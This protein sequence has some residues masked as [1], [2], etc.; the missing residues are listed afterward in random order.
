MFSPEVRADASVK[1][2]G[3]KERLSSVENELAKKQ[4][5][6]EQLRLV[7]PR[8]GT[9]SP[10][11]RVRDRSTLDDAELTG[12]SGTPLDPENLGAML[13]SEGQ[14]N[15]FC[16]IGDANAWDAVLVIDQDDV[17]LVR[18]GQPVRLMFEESAYH[19]YVSRLERPADDAMPY[20]PPRLASTNGGSLPAKAEPDGSVRPLSTSYQAVAPLDNRNGLLRNGLVGR[21]RIETAPRTLSQRVFRYLSRTFNFDL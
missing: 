21:A 19:V 1:I 17:E 5:D 6:L 2:A 15:L 13:S 20:A 3:A 10:P 11:P 4:K 18:E 9:V 8:A 14:Q 12:W 7:A 16:Q